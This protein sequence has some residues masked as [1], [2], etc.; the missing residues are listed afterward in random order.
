MLG[1]L[2]MQ[3][4]DVHSL[5]VTAPRVPRSSDAAAAL[6]AV[7]QQRGYDSQRL[8]R[9]GPAGSRTFLVVRLGDGSETTAG[10]A[11]IDPVDRHVFTSP[12]GRLVQPADLEA[13]PDWAAAIGGDPAWWISG[14]RAINFQIGDICNMH[15]VM[16][17]Q[18]RRR[19]QQPRSEWLP[20]MTADT[21]RAVVEP[22]LGSLHSVELVSFGEPMANPQFDEIVH[23]LGALGHQ[24]RRPIETNIITNG[25]LL[26]LRRHARVLHQPGDLTFSIDA[27]DGDRYEA[28]RVGGR[29]DDVV[30]NLR[31]AVRH[32]QRHAARR[33]GINMTV[34]AANLDGVFAMGAFAAGLGI[35]Y[36]SILHGDGLDV[37]AASGQQ[38]ERGHPSLVD[39]LDRIRRSFPWLQ[40]NDYA[41]GRTLPALPAQ[42]RPGRSFCGLPWRQMDVG[43][44]GHAHP[45]CRAYSIDLGP[46][47]EAWTGE[48][49]RAL[50][51]QMLAGAVDAQRFD[52]CARCPNLGIADRA[53]VAGPPL[54]VAGDATTRRV[55]PLRAS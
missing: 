41:T 24:R 25:S 53:D 44:D 32:P 17:W 54:A 36:L 26:H 8:T 43:P 14:P 10:W 52:A 9:S 13:Q 49:L 46:A 31:M 5:V 34:F 4:S 12:D 16:C 11:V 45:C 2:R 20:E 47:A 35:D 42:T 33:I 39:Q 15:C 30:R 6:A 1:R 18:D 22:H 37:T 55:I 23:T 19:A 48:P 29:W 28:I 51:R 27:A 38:L 21:L 50:R 3:F 7:F 40:L